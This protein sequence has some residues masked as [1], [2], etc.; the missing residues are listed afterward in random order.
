LALESFA[1][2]PPHLAS[3]LAIWRPPANSPEEVLRDGVPFLRN[4]ARQYGL[5]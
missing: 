4:K 1:N 5:L 2:M 3:E